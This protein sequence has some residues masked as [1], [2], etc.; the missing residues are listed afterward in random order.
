MARTGI[1]EGIKQVLVTALQN[2]FTEEFWASLNPETFQIN[3]AQVVM[4]N[5]PQQATAWPILRVDVL[6]SEAHWGNISMSEKDGATADIIGKGTFM[7]DLYSLWSP[8]RDRLSDGLT[9]LLLFREAFPGYNVFDQC[10]KNMAQDGYPMVNLDKGL[11]TFGTDDE[12]MGV[13]WEPNEKIYATSLSVG[14]T[15]EWAMNV[16]NLAEIIKEIDTT[17]NM[18]RK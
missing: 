6:L 13:P 9:A 12:G 17:V 16:D 1:K 2:A 8:G 14:F 3:P 5:Y 11:M 10:I 7:C 4:A 18:E 15:F